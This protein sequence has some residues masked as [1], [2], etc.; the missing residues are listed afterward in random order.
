MDRR[1]RPGRW[2]DRGRW[3]ARC[4]R[5]GRRRRRGRLEWARRGDRRRGWSK[6]IARTGRRWPSLGRGRAQSQ[7]AGAHG[8]REG[9]QDEHAEC[10]ERRP[11][12]SQDRPRVARR[13]RG[14]D[15][16]DLARRGGHRGARPPDTEG[17][18]ATDC[19]SGSKA[20]R[21]PDN[22]EE[23]PRRAVDD[24]GAGI[25]RGEAGPADPRDGDEHERSGEHGSPAHP[26][27]R[28]PQ[29]AGPEDRPEC[30]RPAEQRTS[31]RDEHDQP[32]VHRRSRLDPQDRQG[33]QREAALRD[34]RVA[35]D[36]G[37][38]VLQQ[39]RHRPERERHRAPQRPPGRARSRGRRRSRR[40]P[41][42]PS[43]AGP[44][45]RRRARSRAGRE[46][47]P[48]RPRRPAGRPG[49]GTGSPRSDV[50]ERPRRPRE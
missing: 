15:T 4:R 50:R 37:H 22:P 31:A 39:G 7:A 45:P 46:G 33:Q 1:R 20:R 43:P 36:V 9:G 16:R 42:A 48:M 29:P 40:S 12:Q 21:I 17:H 10:P 27:S 3:N 41:A 25:P 19:E 26:A 18:D 38:V 5:R 14:R 8:H 6:L 47:V 35:G 13:T 32:H 11:V 30:D 34:D 28:V 44:R 49:R 2:R 24:R 23:T